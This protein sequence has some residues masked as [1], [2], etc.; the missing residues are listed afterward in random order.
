MLMIFSR[1]SLLL[2]NSSV[3]FIYFKNLE[4]TSPAL[5]LYFCTCFNFCLLRTDGPRQ[6]L[7]LSSALE[8][9][10]VAMGLC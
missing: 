6:D 5:R 7:L 4:S 9:S 10:V 8:F 1:L 2:Y 3:L